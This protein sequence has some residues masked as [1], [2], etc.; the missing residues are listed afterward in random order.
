MARLKPGQTPEQASALLRAL[1][2]QIREATMP[3]IRPEGARNT[4]P[5]R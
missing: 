3:P 4:C 2:P 5:S 1:Q